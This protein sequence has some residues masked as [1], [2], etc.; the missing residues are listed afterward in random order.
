MPSARRRI[1]AKKKR[2]HL[3]VF[4]LFLAV[5]GIFFFYEEPAHRDI[6]RKSPAVATPEKTPGPAPTFAPPPALPRVSI[7]MDDLGPNKRAAE[8]VFRI[9]APLTLSILPQ[10]V[11][12]AWIAREGHRL[13]HE[14]IGH[15]PMEAQKPHRLGNG[16]LYTWMS[17]DEILKTLKEDLQSIPHIEGVSTHMGSAFT[18]DER[19]MQAVLSELKKRRLLF[20][21]SRTTPKSVGFKL[22]KAQELM[23]LQ[24]DVFLDDKDDPREIE[25]QWKRLVTIAEKRGYAIAQA[26]PRKNTIEFL[27]K[28]LKNSPEVQVVPLSA[29]IEP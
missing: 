10:E 12:T 6:P 21:D 13:G 23:A 11:Y 17:R 25:I 4:V 24:R 22:A 1:K 26:H 19:A 20:L 5:A 29:L 8:R 16:G 7:V 18:Q 9:K 28:T 14:I 27:Q 15:I 3:I 2:R